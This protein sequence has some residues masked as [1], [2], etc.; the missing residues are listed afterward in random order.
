MENYMIWYH[1]SERCKEASNQ[2]RDCTKSNGDDDTHHFMTHNGTRDDDAEGSG[3]ELCGGGPDFGIRRALL[4]SVCYSR[5]WFLTL[6]L[7]ALFP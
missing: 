4:S 5:C 7:V 6:S 2:E 3:G 1:H